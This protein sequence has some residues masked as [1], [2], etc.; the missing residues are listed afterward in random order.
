MLHIQEAVKS[1]FYFIL[2][3]RIKHQ[4]MVGL[5]EPKTV[6]AMS[7]ISISILLITDKQR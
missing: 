6:V 4:F 3:Y 1:I 2:F 5:R 7:I